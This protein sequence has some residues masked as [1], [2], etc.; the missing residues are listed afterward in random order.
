MLR[1]K[2]TNPQ[3]NLGSLPLVIVIKQDGKL[4]F[5]VISENIHPQNAV[6]GRT[7]MSIRVS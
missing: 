7:V 3:S 2:N 1:K 6:N 4:P 5:F